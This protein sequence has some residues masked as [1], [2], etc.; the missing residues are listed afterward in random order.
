MKIIIFDNIASELKFHVA[1]SLENDTNLCLLRIGVDKQISLG[2][3]FYLHWI[4]LPQST[5]FKQKD[6]IIFELNKHR[7][8]TSNKNSSTW[9]CLTPEADFYFKLKFDKVLILE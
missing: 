5:G 9:F 6:T 3:Y 7:L 8:F 4:H 1:D 2:T